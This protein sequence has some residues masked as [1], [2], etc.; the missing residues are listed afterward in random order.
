MK[1]LKSYDQY[2]NESINY[3]DNLIND[4]LTAFLPVPSDIINDFRKEIENALLI[5][6]K[7]SRGSKKKA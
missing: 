1:N 2:I 4:I 6:L 5:N 3:S 7:N